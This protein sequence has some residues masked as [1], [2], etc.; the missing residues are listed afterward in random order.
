MPYVCNCGNKS[1]IRFDSFRR[2]TRCMSCSGTPKYTFKHVKHF[3]AKYAWK[4]LA[5]DYQGAHTKMPCVCKCGEKTMISF[6]KFNQGQRGCAVCSGT[7]K[8]TFKYV[9]RLFKAHNCKLLATKYEN[10]HTK[11]PYV[12]SCGNRS[13]IRL[14]EFNSGRRCIKCGGREK[15]NIRFVRAFFSSRGCKLVSTKYHNARSMLE[16]ICDFGVKHEIAFSTFYNRGTRCGCQ[17]VRSLSLAVAKQI[18]KDGG[19]ELLA[20][21][22]CNNL[23]RMPYTCSCGNQAMISLGHFQDGKRCLKCAGKRH[24]ETRRFN[25]SLGDPADALLKSDER[26]RSLETEAVSTDVGRTDHQ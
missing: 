5:V 8:H 12:C 20:T 7:K 17:A 10:S 11:M 3:F 23:T 2:G 14:S 22:Y 19:C 9:K 16:Y 15:H 26:R 13:T 6:H 4:L 21:N 1:M 24:W 25:K 18:F